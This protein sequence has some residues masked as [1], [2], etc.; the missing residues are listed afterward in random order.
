MNESFKEKLGML[1]GFTIA[2]CAAGLFGIIIFGAV[3]YGLQFF[4]LTFPEQYNHIYMASKNT[5]FHS[6][7][8]FIATMAGY[9]AGA[10][11]FFTKTK[12]VDLQDSSLSTLTKVKIVG[13]SAGV[14][15]ALSS[16]QILLISHLPL[17]QLNPASETILRLLLHFSMGAGVG[18]M[19]HI[20]NKIKS[21][22]SRK[23]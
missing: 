4:G 3:H 5:A 20:M 18:Y 7:Q 10:F 12:P 11:T 14:L 1:L 22:L 21:L 16:G 2:A 15:A 8:A 13:L 19:G 23:S 9:F 17:L 6:W